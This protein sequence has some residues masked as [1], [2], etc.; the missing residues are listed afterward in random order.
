MASH[1]Q[2]SPRYASY[3][4]R[5]RWVERDGRRICQAMLISVATEEQ[6]TFADPS[7]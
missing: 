2:D 7:G 1:S 5:L 3:L 4:L 6:R